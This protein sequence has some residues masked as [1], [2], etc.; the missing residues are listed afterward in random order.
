MN[1]GDRASIDAIG[2]AFTN[3]G[4]DGVSHCSPSLLCLT[5]RQPYLEDADLSQVQKL[6]L[7]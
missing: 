7:L 2:Y 1:A 4:H 6:L 3:I 5:I